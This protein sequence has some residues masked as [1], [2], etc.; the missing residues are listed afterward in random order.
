[1]LLVSLWKT[2][3]TQNTVVL[4]GKPTNNYGKSQFL[5]GKWA[6]FNSKLLNYQRVIILYKALIIE[7]TAPAFLPW[8]RG[9]CAGS[10]AWQRSWGSLFIHPPLAQGTVCVLDLYVL[11]NLEGYDFSPGRMNETSILSSG[12]GSFAHN[13][14]PAKW[15]PGSIQMRRTQTLSVND[16]VASSFDYM[17]G[18]LER[19]ITL[20]VFV[21][22]IVTMAWTQWRELQKNHFDL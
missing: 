3:N 6:I 21:D 17:L 4:S 19:D 18:M 15:Q 20:I 9:L 12:L 11:G 2:G 13:S 14:A 7:V 22:A 8:F 10:Y 16:P 5:M 1:M